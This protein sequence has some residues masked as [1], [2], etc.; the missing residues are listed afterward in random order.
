MLQLIEHSRILF[1][2]EGN[3]HTTLA[4]SSRAANAVDIIW[5]RGGEA[6]S[7]RAPGQMAW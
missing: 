2:E 5:A 6:M 7:L 4:S 3:G 1:G